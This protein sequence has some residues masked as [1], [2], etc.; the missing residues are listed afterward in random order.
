MELPP[1]LNVYV[2][3]ALFVLGAFIF[4][5]YAGLLIWTYRDIHARTRDVLGQILAVVLVA[6]FNLPGLLIYVLVRPRVTLAEAYERELTEEAIM[7]DLEPRKACPKCQRQVEAD[8]I[9]CPYCHEQLKLRCLSC[10]RLLN[11][12]WTICPYCGQDT[13][14]DGLENI[15]IASEYQQH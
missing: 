4:A 2:S 11:P 12:E 13:Q 8:F 6:V 3:A 9:L 10:N 7:R 5:F 15:P 14:A 1:N